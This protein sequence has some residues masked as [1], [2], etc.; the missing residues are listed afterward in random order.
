MPVAKP[1]IAVVVESEDADLVRAGEMLARRLGVELRTFARAQAAEGELSLV[2]NEEG[3]ELRDALTKPGN[4]LTV[5]FSTLNP[6]QA[7]RRG[8]FSRNQPLAKAIG[9]NTHTIIDATAGLGHDAALLACMGFRV[10][11]VERSPVI[12]A[13]LED[14]L[15]RA[16]QVKDLREAFGDRLTILN[17]DAREVFRE[18]AA[19]AIYIDPMFPPKRKSSALAKK[20]IRMVRQVVGDDEDATDLLNHARQHAGR[21]VVKRPTYA[22][23]LSEKPTASITGKLVRYDVYVA[24]VPRS[25][26]S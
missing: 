25:M 8:G 19:D 26:I 17:H 22:P 5:D 20:E 23:H 13:L 21:V 4:G 3:L 24:T 1:L 9:R 2:L 12:F 11:A 15:R 6:R 14:G 7:A 16:M 18:F 10:I